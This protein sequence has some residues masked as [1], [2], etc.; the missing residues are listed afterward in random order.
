MARRDQQINQFDILQNKA[1][2]ISPTCPAPLPETHL[3]LICGSPKMEYLLS[4][5]G[6]SFTVKNVCPAGNLNTSG[7]I[8]PAVVSH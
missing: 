3:V 7:F 2:E 6:A 5:L 1:H 4:P 8:F